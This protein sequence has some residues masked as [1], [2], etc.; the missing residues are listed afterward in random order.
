MNPPCAEAGT[1]SRPFGV[2]VLLGFTFSVFPR[3]SVGPGRGLQG[4]LKLSGPL[5]PYPKCREGA[6]SPPTSLQEPWGAWGKPVESRPPTP[7]VP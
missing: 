3:V 1:V 4:F 5:P 2:R 6:P 7:Q